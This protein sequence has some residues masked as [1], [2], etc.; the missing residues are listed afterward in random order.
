[1]ICGSRNRWSPFLF[2][3]FLLFFHLFVEKET[4]RLA[5]NFDY[6]LVFTLEML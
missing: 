4:F 2:L 3:F 5:D 1:M 6:D